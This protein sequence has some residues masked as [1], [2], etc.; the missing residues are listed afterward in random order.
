MTAV[1]QFSTVMTCCCQRSSCW[2]T[3]ERSLFSQRN[4][5]DNCQVDKTISIRIGSGVVSVFSM[6][7]C[8]KRGNVWG[9]GHYWKENTLQDD[10]QNTTS[11]EVFFS[12]L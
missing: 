9:G 7:P 4:K 12:M 3:V 5:Y 1:Q 11:T 10:L 8:D 6:W 2:C